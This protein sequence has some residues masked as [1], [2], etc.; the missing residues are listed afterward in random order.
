M[1]VSRLTANTSIELPGWRKAQI[2]MQ[3]PEQYDT[4]LVYV[5]QLFI[6]LS[7]GEPVGT[8]KLNGP[9]LK[10]YLAMLTPISGWRTRTR[11][12]R[13]GK[14]IGDIPSFTIIVRDNQRLILTEIGSVNIHLYNQRRRLVVRHIW[15]L[16]FSEILE[17]YVGVI[18]DYVELQDARSASVF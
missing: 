4:F 11:L 5:R 15:P 6:E 13:A 9:A 3:R 17:Q 14:S 7:R 8:T 16:P 1:A 2:R 18:D 12:G 10:D